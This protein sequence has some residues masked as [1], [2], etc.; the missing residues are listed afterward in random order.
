[1]ISFNQFRIYLYPVFDLMIKTGASMYVV[2]HKKVYEVTLKPTDLVA[3]K[4]FAPRPARLKAKK[5]NPHI[6]DY[7]ICDTCAELMVN[8]MCLNPKCPKR[9]IV[10]PDL[11]H[12]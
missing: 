8:K 11:V 10:Y 7:D 5:L 9:E 4:R 2:R 6:L 3:R 12:K 1:M